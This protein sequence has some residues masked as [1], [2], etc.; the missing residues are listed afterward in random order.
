[1]GHQSPISGLP[2]LTGSQ[3]ACTPGTWTTSPAGQQ[4][5]SPWA[6]TCPESSWVTLV[7]CFSFMMTRDSRT[8]QMGIVALTAKRDEGRSGSSPSPKTHPG[9]LSQLHRRV[10]RPWQPLKVLQPFSF[11]GA[12][13]QPNSYDLPCSAPSSLLSPLFLRPLCVSLPCKKPGRPQRLPNRS[14]FLG[15]AGALPPKRR[16]TH[17]CARRT[18]APS[19]C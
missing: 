6:P 11:C 7:L 18:R 14:R 4:L 15:P 19:R 3:A 2:Y 1:M 17:R 16:G 5:G 9:G 10:G 12:S 8:T 13:P